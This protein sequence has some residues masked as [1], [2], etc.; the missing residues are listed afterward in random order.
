MVRSIGYR[1][2]RSKESLN[3]DIAGRG[4]RWLL[5]VRTNGCGVVE[6]FV[7]V[8]DHSPP[9]RGKCDF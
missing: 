3:Y 1:R 4:M 7:L 5:E 2:R 6:V 8:V 9:V